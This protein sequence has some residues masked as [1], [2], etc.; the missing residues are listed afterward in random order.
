MRR[1]RVIDGARMRLMTALLGLADCLARMRRT[2]ALTTPTVLPN[3]PARRRIVVHGTGHSAI[4]AR[5]MGIF[6]MI[7]MAV[8]G[9]GTTDMTIGV[10]GTIADTDAATEMA[11]AIETRAAVTAMA[12][13][14]M[15]PAQRRRRAL[16]RRH[17][18]HNRR[19]PSHKAVR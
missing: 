4:G 14:T 13:A 5:A 18:A 17:R 2:D 12:G 10:A 7:I 3:I 6:M 11:G 15:I 9:A 19:S 16:R 8:Q 1:A